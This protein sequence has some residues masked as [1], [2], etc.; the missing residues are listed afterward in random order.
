MLFRLVNAVQQLTSN[1]KSIFNNFRI[2]DENLLTILIT[3]RKAKYS[4]KY[5]ILR[6]QEGD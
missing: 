5:N 2:I 6:L 4:R 1:E 3:Q